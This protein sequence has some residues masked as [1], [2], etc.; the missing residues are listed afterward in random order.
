MGADT[1]IEWADAT[2][3]VWEGCTKVSPACKN[4][5]AETNSPVRA[6]EMRIGEAL[7][8][9]PNAD[10]KRRLKMWGP[11]GFRYETAN[12]EVLLRALNRKA[13]AAREHDARLG[14]MY[15]RP[16]VF[17]NS[18]SDIF[19]D[20]QG[21]VY[22]LEDGK[23][24]VVAQSLDDVRTRFFRAAEEC[25]ELDILL[26]TKRPENVRTMVPAYWCGVCPT[27]IA[28]GYSLEC[29]CRGRREWPSHIWIGA[30]G[31]DQEHANKRIPELLKVPAKVRFL[32]VEPLLG[33]V[34]FVLAK[35]TL[36]G[37]MG[38]FE[39]VV[40]ANVFSGRVE[41]TYPSGKKL[42]LKHV[43]ERRIHWVIVGG[44]S[45]TNARPMY[46]D[47]VRSIR[48]QC[49]AAGVSFFFK[50]WG[51]WTPDTPN[52]YRLENW[53]EHEVGDVRMYK[54]G[55]KNAGRVLDGRTWDEVPR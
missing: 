48:D 25:T 35:E 17:I 36:T 37:F 1:K 27:C 18:L 39:Y 16:R 5:Y 28:V 26:L 31:E 2:I 10:G 45:G 30:T 55:K 8:V 40:G 43:D 46:P 52:G 12:W 50:Q 13:K 3:N 15:T 49:V 32:S 23:P 19:E 6:M 51:E 44:E 22:R 21:P 34:D 42:A 53:N 4:C 9:E 20:W 33:P 14:H 24:V 11:R 29:V 54:V 41:E 38:T 47:W 7:G